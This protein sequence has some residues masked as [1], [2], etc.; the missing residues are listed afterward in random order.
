MDAT[1]AAAVTG[2]F[3]LLML[4]VEKSRRENVRDH[5]YVKDALTE[6]KENIADVDSDVKVI[7][8]KIDTHIN[9]HVAM[10]LTE[11]QSIKSKKSRAK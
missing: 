5:G 2:A 1:W 7:E 6:I 10:A 3:G 11:L 4:L 8:A 9:D